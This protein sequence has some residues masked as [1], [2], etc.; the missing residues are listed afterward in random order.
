MSRVAYLVLAVA[1][2][3]T[4]PQT[5]GAE[6]P[7][8]STHAVEAGPLVTSHALLKERLTRIARRSPSWRESI[9]SLVGTGKTVF[10][11]TPDEVVVADGPDGSE[12]GTFDP[13]VVA[14]AAP[15]PGPEGQVR[16][17]L[18][19]VN[20]PLIEDVHRRGDSPPAELLSDIDSVLVHEIY[21]HALPYL[22]AGSL[23]GR[24]PDPEPGQAA[25]EACSIRRENTIRT[26]LR[27]GRRRGYGL[28]ALSL[29]RGSWALTSA[30]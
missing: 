16:S 17:V 28:D 6:G 4:L 3:S 18:V 12:A 1:G 14:A 29:S 22:L 9:A 23:S 5:A 11:L 10:V 13:A 24:C 19:F 25:S 27:M 21:G 30:R 15:V 8:S 20:L 26:E 7:V 2:F